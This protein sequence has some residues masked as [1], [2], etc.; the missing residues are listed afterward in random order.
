M[1]LNFFTMSWPNNNHNSF[2]NDDIITS[3]SLKTTF[4]KKKSFSFGVN[5]QKHTFGWTKSNG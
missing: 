3:S 1:S 2:L 4:P 5:R